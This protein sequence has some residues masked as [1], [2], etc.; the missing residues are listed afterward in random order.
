MG[1]RPYR[2]R[3]IPALIC[4][5]RCHRWSGWSATVTFGGRSQSH[6]PPAERRV[7]AT[8]SSRWCDRCHTTEGRA[9]TETEAKQALAEYF[10][11]AEE[12]WANPKKRRWLEWLGNAGRN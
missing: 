12:E 6:L 9:A 11:Q 5:E 4:R 10:A 3:P 2:K 1:M 7:F 8:E